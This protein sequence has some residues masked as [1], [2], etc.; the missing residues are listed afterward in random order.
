MVGLRPCDQCKKYAIRA[1]QPVSVTLCDT[2]IRPPL[3]SLALI[4]VM[5]IF[6]LVCA[7]GMTTCAL[8]RDGCG[9]TTKTPLIPFYTAIFSTAFEVFY[10]FI[11]YSFSCSFPPVFDPRSINLFVRHNGY[12]HWNATYES[13]SEVYVSSIYQAVMLSNDVFK[14]GDFDLMYDGT[15]LI[16]DYISRMPSNRMHG[17]VTIELVPQTDCLKRALYAVMADNFMRSVGVIK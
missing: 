6:L 9:I 10:R 4:A 11:M 16:P 14:R 13:L 3:W 7:V 8:R 2:C 1:T 15:R 17:N 12:T 5:S